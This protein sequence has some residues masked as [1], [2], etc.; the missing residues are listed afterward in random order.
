[1]AKKIAYLGKA[2]GCQLLEAWLVEQEK[3]QEGS[4]AF[5]ESGKAR[6]PHLVPCPKQRGWWIY[7]EACDFCAHAERTP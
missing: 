2:E 1:M 4:R 3:K 7:R 5:Y 6:S